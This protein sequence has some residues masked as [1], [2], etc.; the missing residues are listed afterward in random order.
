MKEITK[1]NSIVINAIKFNIFKFLNLDFRVLYVNFPKIIKYGVN[2][3][4]NPIMP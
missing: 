4:I 3:R 2:T 1:I